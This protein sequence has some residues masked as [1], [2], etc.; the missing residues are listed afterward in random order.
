VNLAGLSTEELARGMALATADT[1]VPRPRIDALLSLLPS[2]KP[3]KD[4]ARV[5][6]HAYTTETIA[7]AR[8]VW[9]RKQLNEA[10][11]RSVCAT[12]TSPNPCA[13]ARRPLHRA[14]VFTGRTIGGGVVLDASPVTRKQR[15][16]DAIAFLKI[17][18]DGSPGTS[19]GSSRP[20]G[21]EQSACAWTIYPEK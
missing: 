13:S 11:R 1:F 2:A 14:S 5:H 8:L 6:F 15:A 7:E 9:R 12:K 19:A 16:A 10:R 21:E 17:L 4:G 18:R 3:F 20:P